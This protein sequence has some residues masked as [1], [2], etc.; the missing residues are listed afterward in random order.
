MKDISLTY[1]EKFLRNQKSFQSKYKKLFDKVANDISHLVNDPSAKFSKSFN[2]N[3]QIEKKITA[4]ISQFQKENLKLTESEIAESW[5]LSNAK[6]DEIVKD[7]IK[8]VTV[9][10]TAEKAALFIPN[11][12]ALEAFIARDR[13]VG[14]LSDAIW[15]VSAQLRAECEIH[16]GLSIL[17]G[18][19][20]QV[21]SRRIRKYLENPE[22]LF[23]RVRDK[24]GKLVASKAMIENAPGQGHYNSAYKNAIRVARTET[25]QAFQ[26]AD[27]IRWKQLDFVRGVKIRLSEQHPK[28]NFVEICEE[29]EGEY[30]T[31]FTFIGWHPVCLCSATPILMPQDDFERSLAGEDIKAVPIEKMP[32]N[33]NEYVKSNYERYSNYKN[34][35]YW[36]TENQSIVDKII[37]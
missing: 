5:R 26:M 6:N 31:Q 24:N 16:L 9:L 33:F 1:R 20:A 11:T 29:M 35:P 22:A 7:Y 12:S 3:K 15:K 36:I 18:D 28:Y 2:F 37:K 30:P 8:T 32:E 13:G 34:M 21:T 10:Q 23:R 27:A 25:N 19:S 14:T 17:N 4:I